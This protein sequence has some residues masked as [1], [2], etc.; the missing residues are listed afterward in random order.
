MKAIL[1]SA[2]LGTRLL[3]LTKI[4]PKCMMP[5]GGRPLMEYWL[6]FLTDASIFPILINLH[7]HKDFVLEWIEH[8]QYKDSILTSCEP[9]LLGTGG[10]VLNNMKFIGNEPV[11]L[12]HADNL[13]F[14]N[15]DDFVASHSLRPKNTAITMMTFKTR[16][17]E[18]CGVV[19][20]DNNGI[21]Q[22]FYE[23]LKKPPVK[24]ISVSSDGD[25][26]YIAN[27][28]V[29]IIE[30]EVVKFLV[31]LR[32]S[33]KKQITPFFTNIDFS[34]D[35]LPNYLGRIYTYHNTA[36]H[37]D[38]GTPTN[39]MLAQAQPYN[40]EMLLGLNNNKFWEDKSEEIRGLMN[41]LKEVA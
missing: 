20:C 14:A 13:C 18:Q 12:I 29:Y 34:N 23:K 2:G 21:V 9:E 38:I 28:A 40:T 36:V 19:E 8:S 39:L 33:C 35:V 3:P 7:H 30:P 15:I 27:G 5:I 17:P 26:L 22:K 32:S 11:M 16:N 31:D 4:W 10:T 37:I 6:R 24:P 1:L 25:V 41:L